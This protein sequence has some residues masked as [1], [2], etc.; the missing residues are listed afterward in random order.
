MPCKMTFMDTALKRFMA[1]VKFNQSGCWTW[2]GAKNP[3]G[4]ANFMYPRKG[5]FTNAH[6][7]SY[8]IF[9]GPIPPNLEIDHLCRIRHCVNPF[10]LELVTSAENNRRGYSASAI[11]QRKTH[12]IY[13]HPLSGDNLFMQIR[14]TSAP[15]R[16]CKI[17]RSRRMREYRDNHAPK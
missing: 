6:V 8:L 10:H 16:I 3:N 9:R 2:T 12:C 15:S 11:N 1:K 13:G 4:Y 7:V 5:R 14:K 17:C